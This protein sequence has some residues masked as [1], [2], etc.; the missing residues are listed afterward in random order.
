MNIFTEQIVF[1]EADLPTWAETI[2]QLHEDVLSKTNNVAYNVSYGNEQKDIERAIYSA[3][4][5]SN[6]DERYSC[7]LNQIATFAA[8][9]AQ[10]HIFT[11]GNKR[12]AAMIPPTMLNFC[13][14]GLYV[15]RL[16]DDDLYKCIQ[17]AT[18]KQITELQFAEVLKN[19]LT[20]V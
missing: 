6:C 7:A 19:A 18:T 13:S 2:M 14:G 1:E 3:F 17:Q 15:L 20:K 8:R 12:T 4:C 9:L 16:S 10:D 11:D 5:V